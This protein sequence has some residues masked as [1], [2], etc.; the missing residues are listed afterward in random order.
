M[1]GAEIHRWFLKN[2]GDNALSSRNVNV[3]IEMFTNDRT[4]VKHEGEEGCP[5]TYTTDVMI[6]QAREMAKWRVIIDEVER[7][8]EMHIT[9]H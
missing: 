8:L 2:D 9:V 3:W 5:S 4:S 1:P 6:Q 7:S